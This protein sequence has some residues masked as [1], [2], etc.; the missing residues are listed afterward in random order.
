MHC[1]AAFSVCE[2]EGKAQVYSLVA[3]SLVGWPAELVL[4]LL[5]KELLQIN[6]PQIEKII[7]CCHPHMFH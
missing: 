5:Q 7:S 6:H 3:A 2:E 4:T 1:G